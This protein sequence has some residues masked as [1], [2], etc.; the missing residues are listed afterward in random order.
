[1]AIN[2]DSLMEEINSYPLLVK[3]NFIKTENAKDSGKTVS[4]HMVSDASLDTSKQTGH[5]T[6][7]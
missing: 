6:P 5:R 3:I 4:V 2:V 1:M 7:S